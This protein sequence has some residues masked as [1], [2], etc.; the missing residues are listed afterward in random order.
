M[1]SKITELIIKE[2]DWDDY[3]KKINELLNKTQQDIDNLLHIVSG[4]S[5][6]E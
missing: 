5:L 4:G 3:M 2:E 1:N 6:H